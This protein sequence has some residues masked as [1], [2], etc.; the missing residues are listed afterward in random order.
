METSGAE[1]QP[2]DAQPPTHAEPELPPTEH[3][4]PSHG[5][6]RVLD[7]RE[8][9]WFSPP[10]HGNRVAGTR[11]TGGFDNHPGHPDPDRLR[12]FA[13]APP[14]EA[15]G[16]ATQDDPLAGF[17]AEPAPESGLL[18]PPAVGRPPVR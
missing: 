9:A 3:H 11:T 18:P 7:D 16:G 2:L 8:I 12:I 17:R 1:G 14:A 5:A 10:T 13:G 4:G 15:P 6:E